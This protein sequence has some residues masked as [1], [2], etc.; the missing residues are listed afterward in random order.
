MDGASLRSPR[1]R[2]EYVLVGDRE[3]FRVNADALL[4]RRAQALRGELALFG[5]SLYGFGPN[6]ELLARQVQV[7]GG[8]S[9]DVT[10]DVDQAAELRTVDLTADYVPARLTGRIDGGDGP[11][12]LAVAVNGHIEAVAR[13]Y[14]VEGVERLS[15]LI[16]ESALRHGANDV[17]VFWVT[18]GIELREIWSS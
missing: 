7:L 12:D 11:R 16:P 10:A 14:V 3:T 8:V 15:V 6:P 9:S 17:R 13:S 1:A 4:A 18:S 5:D 2:E